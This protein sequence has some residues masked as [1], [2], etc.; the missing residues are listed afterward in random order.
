MD[1]A[2]VIVAI[3]IAII[4]II[5]IIIIIITFFLIFSTTT[6]FSSPNPS[7]PLLIDLTLSPQDLRQRGLQVCAVPG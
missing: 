5:T 3:A 6:I 2:F 1:R 7:S 4:I